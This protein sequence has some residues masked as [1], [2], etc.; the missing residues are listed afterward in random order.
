MRSKK[1]SSK[2]QA[3][4]QVSLFS[5]CTADQLELAASLVDETRFRAGATLTEQ[6]ASSREAFVIVSGTAVVSLDGK[7]ISTLG[8]GDAVGEMGLLDR[9]PRS[10]TVT[11]ETDVEVLVVTE[12][13]LERLIRET[14]VARNLLR[15]LARRLREFESSATS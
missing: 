5:A 4:Q 8:P 6:G 11:A 2:A 15:A 7:Q 10:A 3:L 1:L 13:S 12:Q 9:A 14:P